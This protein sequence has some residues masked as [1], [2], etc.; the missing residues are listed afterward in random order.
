MGGDSSGRGQEWEGTGVGGDRSGR[1]QKW[2]G[3][4]VGR[5]RRGVV[6]RKMI[7]INHMLV[8]FTQLIN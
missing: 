5:D 6:G 8:W 1:G 4:G 7:K 3:A 2:E